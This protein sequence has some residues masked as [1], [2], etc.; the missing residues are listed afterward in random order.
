MSGGT[1][2]GYLGPGEVWTAGTSEEP[3]PEHGDGDASDWEFQNYAGIDL[4]TYL[5]EVTEQGITPG[6]DT[7]FCWAPSPK[8]GRRCT[9]L[10]DDDTETCAAGHTPLRLR[11][12]V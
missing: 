1:V 4:S 11:R 10:V 6:P 5:N 7:A 9:H 2:V 3:H 12:R 8:T